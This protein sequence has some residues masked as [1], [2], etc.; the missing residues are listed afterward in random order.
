MLCSWCDR[1]ASFKL[2]TKGIYH[3]DYACA[4]HARIYGQCFD[5]VNM[6]TKDVSAQ[7]LYQT[8]KELSSEKKGENSPL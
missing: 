2:F 8:Q 7:E 3:V 5:V 6:K 4:E 1:A